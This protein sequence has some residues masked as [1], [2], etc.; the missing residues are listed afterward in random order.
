MNIDQPLMPTASPDALQST[1]PSSGPK[2]QASTPPPTQQDIEA[3]FPSQEPKFEEFSVRKNAPGP[4]PPLVPAEPLL[5]NEIQQITAEEFERSIK[6]AEHATEGLRNLKLPRSV[7]DLVDLLGR[8]LTSTKRTF[9]ETGEIPA[10]EAI[11][12]QAVSPGGHTLHGSNP[13]PQKRLRKSKP[14]KPVEPQSDVS[15]LPPLDPAQPQDRVPQES[16][17]DAAATIPPSSPAATNNI[18]PN[19]IPIEPAPPSIHNHSDVAPDREPPPEIPNPKP[20]A[21]IPPP[22]PVDP[23]LQQTPSTKEPLPTTGTDPGSDPTLTQ[24][25]SVERADLPPGA[26]TPN[27]PTALQTHTPMYHQIGPLPQTPVNLPSSSLMMCES[28]SSRS[29][30]ALMEQ[31]PLGKGTRPPGPR[32]RIWFSSGLN[33]CRLQI[34]PSTS[35]TSNVLHAH[36]HLGFRQSAGW[37]FLSPSHNEQWYCPD[38]LDFDLLAKFG[39]KENPSEPHISIL[40][41]TPHPESTL[42]RFLYRLAH[43]S[44]PSITEWSKIVAASVELMAD[45]LY[46]PPAPITDN[47]DQL[48]QGVQVLKQI[49]AIKNSSSS[50][51]TPDTDPSPDNPQPAPRASSG[52]VLHEFRSVILDVYTAYIIFQTH[53]LSQ[54]PLSQTKKKAESRNRRNSARPAAGAITNSPQGSSELAKVRE[55]S[56]R[57]MASYQRRQNFQPLIFF[58]LGGV[59]GLFLVSRNYRSAST[60]DCMS[61]IQA[62]TIIKQHSTSAHT[63]A[64]PIWKKPGSLPRYN[65]CPC[66]QQPDQNLSP[67]EEPHSTRDCRGNHS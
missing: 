53:A 44:Q 5:E 49:E 9:H 54:A 37:G 46:A 4:P 50:F 47:D 22:T 3:N 48:V 7:K 23:E 24:F 27:P 64:E 35:S 11:K 51:D 13:P 61:F 60:S 55:E 36:T 26:P 32:S 56:T 14:T 1:N 28:K 39:N 43:P 58:L 25:P 17:S 63:P 15:Q 19:N 57:Q 8:T 38:V 21:H 52:D 66:L 41:K 30:K 42:V 2:P 29:M 45:N 10:G 6:A 62:I 18:S 12:I 65:I 40:S 20:A 59:R 67:I 16:P 33:Q 34:H 31:N